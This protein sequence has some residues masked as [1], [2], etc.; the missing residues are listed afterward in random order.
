MTSKIATVTSRVIPVFSRSSGRSLFYFQ[1]TTLFCLCTRT[2]GSDLNI[3]EHVSWNLLEHRVLIWE[4]EGLD[5]NPA[6][7]PRHLMFLDPL[8]PS[9]KWWSRIERWFVSWQLKMRLKRIRQWPTRAVSSDRELCLTTFPVHNI[10]WRISGPL[11]WSER[12]QTHRSHRQHHRSSGICD[13]GPFAALPRLRL[14]E[15][16]E[17]ER[18]TFLPK[19]MTE[20]LLTSYTQWFQ[21]RASL[22]STEPG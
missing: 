5:F 6:V 18:L 20:A 15:A 10:V 17:R 2:E 9:E 7:R 22:C 12:G 14:L 13:K 11:R 1:P 4:S 19:R 3:Q 8:P 16:L 21:A